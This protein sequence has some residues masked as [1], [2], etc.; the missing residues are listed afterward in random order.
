MVVADDLEDLVADGHDRVQ[1]R[2][3]ILK[4]HRDLTAAHLTHFLFGQLQKIVSFVDDL[5]GNN[6]SGRVRDQAHDT[7]RQCCFAC[8]GL[9]DQ[10]QSLAAPNLQI[11]VVQR[12]NHTICCGIDDV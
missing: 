5:T 2:H 1:R 8:A 3:G 12:T 7:A 4:D 6:F 11:C 9:A 10:T